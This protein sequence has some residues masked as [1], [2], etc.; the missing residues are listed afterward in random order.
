MTLEPLNLITDTS[1]SYMNIYFSGIGGVGVG[2][3]A[4]L[5]QDAGN[6][7]SGSDPEVTPTVKD[8]LA[9]GVKFSTD[10][11]G[12]FI[13]AINKEQTIDLFVYTAALPADHP[14]IRYAKEY[15]ITSVK[16]HELINQLLE[17]KNLKMIAV[18]GT[19]GKTTTTGM[20]IWTFKELGIPA[21]YSIGTRISFGPSACYQSES[22]YF[23][24]EADEFDR[25]MLN[26]E[27]YI[28][29]IPSIDYD[30]PDTYSD[31]KEYRIAFEQFLSKSN[32]SVGWA[33][34]SLNVTKSLKEVRPEIS[35]PGH[36]KRNA[37]L[38]YEMMTILFDD[39]D[40]D[41]LISA[42]NSFPGTDRRFEK[43]EENLYTDYAHHPAEIAST[44][45]L[46]RELNNSVIVVYQPH[47]NI[48]QHHIV[49]HG[50][51][52]DCFKDAQHVYWIP[53]YLSREDKSL[54]TIEPGE[55]IKTTANEHM[56]SVA[57]MDR[58]LKEIINKHR[59]GD[60]LVIG[61]S[62][63]DLDEWLRKIADNS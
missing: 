16:R 38:V 57:Q 46:A 8:L 62:A 28:S 12:K 29:V 49:N 40:K 24:Y 20:L 61:M 26:F 5:A 45:K 37:T 11:S 1:C 14:E 56:F 55:L 23:I 9:R 21:S 58:E 39:I 53:T 13:D 25:N 59:D 34:D 18:S 22:E 48:R 2:P 52:G 15:A 19:H 33:E 36:N 63:G 7:V 41:K 3:L 30:H 43:L 60:S 42:L 10:Q 47:Q 6:T 4:M 54:A 32:M 17:Y 31:E 35:L 50:G 51:Y 27:P 44:L